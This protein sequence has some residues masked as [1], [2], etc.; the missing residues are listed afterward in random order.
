MERRDFLLKGCSLCLLGAAGLLLPGLTGC[1]TSKSSVYKT[2]VVNKQVIVPLTLFAAGG[3]QRVRPKGWLYDIA[4]QKTEEGQYI[5]LLMKCTHMDNPLYA[6][7]GG[8]TCNVHG[9][10][11]DQNGHV[12]KGPASTP[13]K[14]FATTVNEDNLIINI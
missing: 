4:V 6:N 3:I 14:H 11:F 7:K 10:V 1:A 13:L 9:S 8:F 2:S 12:K 5:A